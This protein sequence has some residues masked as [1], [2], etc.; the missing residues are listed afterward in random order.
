[1]LVDDDVERIQE[2][3]QNEE[4]LEQYGRFAFELIK[5]ECVVEKIKYEKI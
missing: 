3:R 4:F 1:M 5:E 2:V